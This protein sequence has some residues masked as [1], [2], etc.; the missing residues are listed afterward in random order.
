M[1]G[2][3][4]SFAGHIIERVLGHGGMGTVYLAKHPRLPRSVALKLLHRELS[5]D[6]AVRRRFEREADIVA[7]LEHPGIVGILDRGSHDDQLWISMPFVRGTDAGRLRTQE[8][9]A[10]RATRIVTEIG[11]ALDYAHAHG[12]LHRDVKPANI[13]LTEASGGL[14]ER[15]VLTDFGIARL[16]D[17]SRV[18][19]AGSVSATL[20]Y[21]SPEQLLGTT[22]DERS[23][24]YSLAC[25]LYALLAGEPPYRATHPGRV[26]TGHLNQ[27]IPRLA[28]QRGDLPDELDAVIARGAAKKAEDRY[29]NC[30]D[31]A[32][33]ARFSLRPL[34][35]VT[36]IA[37]FPPTRRTSPAL[38]VVAPEDEETVVVAAV[39]PSGEPV[40]AREVVYWTVLVVAVVGMLLAVW[41][42]IGAYSSA[43]L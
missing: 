18:T 37:P 19:P 14:P 38:P 9:S 25:T 5:T 3:G 27:P 8:V 21:A 2:V 17:S 39:A 31:F 34:P 42:L 36:P 43:F 11:D 6:P 26:I 1:I 30:H 13:L 35:S 24:Q 4:D 29:P 20:A 10:Q 40:T 33:A 15:A 7:G 28:E 12:V 32:T 41:A 16:V 23:D 22:V